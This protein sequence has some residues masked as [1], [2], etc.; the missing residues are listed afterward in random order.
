MNDQKPIEE[1]LSKKNI[2]CKCACNI[3]KLE[4]E[5]KINIFF[6]FCENLYE[7]FI[8]K[9]YPENKRQ[10]SFN[11]EKNA[12]ANKIFLICKFTKS[13]NFSDSLHS[14]NFVKHCYFSYRSFYFNQVNEEIISN[15]GFLLFALLFF[16]NNIQN[17][18]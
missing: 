2:S 16:R 6:C 11:I 18:N 9:K 1:D 12:Q 7:A 10:K 14:Y 15:S 5:V 4:Q 17:K 3:Y 13:S 8:D